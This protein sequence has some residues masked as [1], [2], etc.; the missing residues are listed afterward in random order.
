MGGL[1]AAFA[2]TGDELYKT[3]AYDLG[4]RLLPAFDT[5]TGI[6]YGHINLLTGVSIHMLRLP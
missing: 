1:L 6:P 5:P 4:K 3:K 2:L